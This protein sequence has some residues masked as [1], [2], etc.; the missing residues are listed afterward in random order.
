[1]G[2]VQNAAYTLNCLYHRRFRKTCCGQVLNDLCSIAIPMWDVGE[3]MR[4]I[5]PKHIP[6]CIVHD[7]DELVVTDVVPYTED[8]CSSWLQYSL[9]VAKTE[10]LV[11]E[12]HHAKLT[13]YSVKRRICEWQL[14]SIS[15]SPFNCKRPIGT[16]CRLTAWS[17]KTRV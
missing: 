7:V 11:I 5:I 2:S 17:T 1:M 16:A 3:K 10:H 8:K 6:S 4:P 15:L 14:Q 12:K 9:C 13:N